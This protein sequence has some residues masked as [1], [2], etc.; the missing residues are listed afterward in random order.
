MMKKQENKEKQVSISPEEIV[1]LALQK[2]KEIE[3]TISKKK[4]EITRRIARGARRT[5]GPYKFPL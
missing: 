3:K 1:S 5:S 4:A 2:V